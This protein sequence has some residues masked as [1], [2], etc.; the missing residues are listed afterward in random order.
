MHTEAIIGLDSAWTNKVPGA[1]CAVTSIGGQLISFEPPRLVRFDEAAE[2][3]ESTSSSVDLSL[4]ALDQ[5]S[6]VP[7]ATSIRPVERVAGSIVNGLGGGV[8]P[9]NRNKASMFG[10]DAPIWGFLDRIS[11]RENP[12]LSRQADR[13]LFLMEVF[14][15]LALPTLVPEIWNRR[16]AA[17][18]NPAARKTYSS[19]DWQLVANGIADLAAQSGLVPVAD[20]ATEL[21]RLPKPNKAD[22]DKLDA[23]IC[24]M[25]GWVWQHHGRESSAVI[26][27]PVSGY[28]V[29]PASHAV[30]DVLTRSAM[31]KGVPI[32]VPWDH[33]AERVVFPDAVKAAPA[34]TPKKPSPRPKQ[35]ATLAPNQQDKK[36]CP[37]CGRSFKGT[38]WGGIDAHWRSHH[39]DIMPY[40]RAWPIIRR[41][42]RPSEEMPPPFTPR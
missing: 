13:G 3:I 29:T 11:A 16:K 33:D 12:D 30:K 35:R 28:M 26:G 18:Y 2:F 6:L 4:V 9:A 17:K 10:S 23:L 31:K 22:Q 20:C 39:E 27:D 1:I 41:G 24:L 14:P 21:A 34:R 19:D 40:D 5:P 25:V 38:G 36:A 42:G 8:Q 32:D 37:E 15:A 7:N